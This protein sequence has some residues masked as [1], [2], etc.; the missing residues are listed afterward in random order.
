MFAFFMGI[1]ILYLVLYICAMVY[2]NFHSSYKHH[3]D[4]IVGDSGL[5][6]DSYNADI[7]SI[8]HS[9]DYLEREIHDDFG[10]WLRS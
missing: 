7:K 4:T 3:S 5:T 6:E 9:L 8:K 10:K 1:Y 2:D